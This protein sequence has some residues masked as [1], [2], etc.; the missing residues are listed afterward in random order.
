MSRVL[1]LSEWCV[2]PLLRYFV[3]VGGALLALL[4]LANAYLPA[5]GAAPQ[6]QS[7]GIDK[8][9]IRIASRQKGP[10]RVEIDTSLP[11]IVPTVDV[12]QTQIQPTHTA[13]KPAK[14]T[15]ADNRES[16]AQMPT[17]PAKDKPVATA[18]PKKPKVRVARAD[19][20]RHF[21]Q[22]ARVAMLPRPPQQPPLF[23]SFF[24]GWQVR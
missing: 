21:A 18:A 11:T 24:G 17:L 22:P 8:S 15:V 10:E 23:A 4:L 6:Q 1:I 19:G 2:M 12:A 13:A 9:T 16:Y 5:P 20:P 7:A 3:G 14:E